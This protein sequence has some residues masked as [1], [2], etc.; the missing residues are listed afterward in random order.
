MPG[1]RRRDD[2]KQ[3]TLKENDM[4]RLT[5]RVSLVRI[6]VLLLIC[7][8]FLASTP[9]F[10]GAQGSGNGSIEDVV[11]IAVNDID[12]LWADLFAASDIDYLGPDVVLYD[13]GV[14]TPCGELTTGN[15]YSFYCSDDVTL[16]LDAQ[17]L[18]YVADEHGTFAVAVVI[19]DAWGYYLQ[20]ALDVDASGEAATVGATC[21][22]GAWTWFAV[23]M[24]MANEADLSGALSYYEN[25]PD[26][27]LL[28]EVFIFG[29]ETESVADCFVE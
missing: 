1:E 29:F 2:T 13:G 22:A 16:Y 18:S 4:S 5:N 3:S 20:D 14:S 25:L 7:L 21:L 17:A 24:G 23:D 9:G 10:A 19:A 28:A 27:E 12:S 11:V 8:A 26:G 15:Y 6:P